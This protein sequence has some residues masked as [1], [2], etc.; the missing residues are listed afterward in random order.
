MIVSPTATTK[1]R[2]GTTVNFS[3]TGTDEEDGNLAANKFKW[4][5]EFYHGNHAQNSETING[6]KKDRLRSP[7]SASTPATS[8]SAFI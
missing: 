7:H 8:S 3:G 2:G 6:V 5:V 4:L 1:Y